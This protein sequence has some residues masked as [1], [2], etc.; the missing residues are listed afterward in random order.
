M[1][2]NVRTVVTFREEGGIVVGRRHDD[3]WVLERF[4]FQGTCT[5]D[6]WTKPKGVDSRVGGEDAG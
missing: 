5:K 3:F 6:T 1:V 4:T 2:L